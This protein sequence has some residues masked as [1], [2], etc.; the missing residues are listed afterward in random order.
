[1]KKISSFFLESANG[2]SI[3]VAALFLPLFLIS[4]MF[5]EAGRRAY[6]IGI[7]VGIIFGIVVFFIGRKPPT[8]R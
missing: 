1:M 2:R 6:L 5:D 3:V 8:R 4:K 7:V